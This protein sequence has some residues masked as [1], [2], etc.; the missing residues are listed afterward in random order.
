MLQGQ[1]LMSVR[2]HIL[3][4]ACLCSVLV[5]CGDPVAP[6][7]NSSDETL[8][9]VK[10]MIPTRK[11]IIQT[12]TQPATFHP[13]YQADI[14]AKVSG[15]V[16]EVLVD[17]GDTVTE[18]Q[19]LGTLD[20]P[21]MDKQR[22]QAVARQQRL[23]A[24][25]RRAQSA[26]E[27]AVAQVAAAGAGIEEAASN[28]ER[29]NA[30]LIADKADLDRI[31]GLVRKQAATVAM[32]D[33]AQSEHDV[34]AASR[35]AAEASVRSADAQLQIAIAE[36]RAAEAEVGTAE[37]R[38][39]ESGKAIEEI[40]AMLAYTTLR[41]PFAGVITSR[42]VDP[43]DFVAGSLATNADVK[44]PLFHVD[45][46]QRLRVRV[47]VPERDAAHVDAGDPVSL[48]CEAN[49]G[50]LLEAT[51]TRVARRLD[52]S[53]R[54]MIAEIDLENADG[55]LLPGM[56][57]QATITALVRKDSLVLPASAVRTDATGAAH[58]LTL[59]DDDEVEQQPI[60][61]GADTGREIEVVEGLA[62]GERV[63]DAF[64]GT[65]KPGQ[66]V[67]VVAPQ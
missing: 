52:P 64:V 33:E 34:S 67:M 23:E 41:A 66:K 63:I 65:I 21:E 35:V 38:L 17:I 4:A 46:Q 55:Q 13:Y 15:Y 37:A 54:T 31:M 1:R 39:A 20:V 30:R 9:R 14:V 18:G 47:A 26:V 40:D 11:D 49:L 43:G 32:L 59:S 36:Q 2:V 56:F 45:Q 8:P 44:R 53:T 58:V 57:G 27:V 61:I 62:G 51:V 7:P 5:G 29:E 10:V 6:Q 28:V 48:V 60:S 19:P 3:S 16:R 42:H 24:E 25:L 50:E 12:T 22:E